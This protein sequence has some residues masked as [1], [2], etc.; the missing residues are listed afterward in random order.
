MNSLSSR[1]SIKDAVKR[2]LDATNVHGL[3]TLRSAKNTLPLRFLFSDKTKNF[4]DFFVRRDLSV[5]PFHRDS[6]TSWRPLL[7]I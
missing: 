3:V 2:Y 6:L 1:R 7:L 4:D 5:Y